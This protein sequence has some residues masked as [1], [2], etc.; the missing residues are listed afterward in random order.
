MASEAHVFDRGKKG[1]LV[2]CQQLLD[3]CI[4]IAVQPWSQPQSTVRL[5]HFRQHEP[6]D[7]ATNGMLGFLMMICPS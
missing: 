2:V 7:H 4:K 5:D 6:L 1:L 3:K